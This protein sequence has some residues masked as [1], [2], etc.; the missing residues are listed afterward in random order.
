MKFSSIVIVLLILVTCTSERTECY[1]P[2]TTL[3]NRISDIN[4]YCFGL[5]RVEPVDTIE[6]QDLNSALCAAATIRYTE[7]EGKSGRNRL[8]WPD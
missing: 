7:C 1:D 4:F 6:E 2:D 8:I 5:G 3:G